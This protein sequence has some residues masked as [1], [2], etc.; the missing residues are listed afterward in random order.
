MKLK[1]FRKYYLNQNEKGFTDFINSVMKTNPDYV[2]PVAKKCCRLLKDIK[3][4]QETKEKIYYKQ[5]FI[6]N[7]VDLKGKKIAVIDDAVKNASTLSEH[8]SYFEKKGAQV[9][10]YA[11]VGKK[12]WYDCT[13]ENYDKNAIAFH[14]LNDAE[15]ETYIFQQAQ[16][17]SNQ[18]TLCFDNEHLAFR[19]NISNENYE[20]LCSEL[21]NLGYVEIIDSDNNQIEKITLD[22]DRFFSE[23]PYF[24]NENIQMGFINKLRL[25]YSFEENTLLIFPLSFPKWSNAKTTILD[26]SNIPFSLPFDACESNIEKSYFNICFLYS[27]SLFKAF[28]QK[29]NTFFDSSPVLLDVDLK[30]YLKQEKVNNIIHS[31]S[32]FIINNNQQYTFQKNFYLPHN[33]KSF[34]SIDPKKIYTELKSKYDKRIKNNKAIL[35]THF[36]MPISKMALKYGY[37]YNLSSALDY[38]CD[39]GSIVSKNNYNRRTDICERVFRSGEVNPSINLQKSKVI[40]PLAIRVLGKTDTKENTVFS[41]ATKTVKSIAN[42]VVDFPDNDHS[43][44]NKPYL[45]GPVPHVKDTLNPESNSSIYNKKEEFSKYY[46]FDDKKFKT[47]NHNVIIEDIKKNLTSNEIS[48]YRSYFKLLSKITKLFGKDRILTSLAI[49]RD[50]YHYKTYIIYNITNCLDALGRCVSKISSCDFGNNLSIANEHAESSRDKLSMAESFSQDFKK[51]IDNFSFDDEVYEML[52]HIISN[53]Y[54][55]EDNILNTANQFAPLI[56]SMSGLVELL[57]FLKYFDR[58][59]YKTCLRYLKKAQINCQPLLSIYNPSKKN[60]RVSDLTEEDINEMKKYAS[61]ILKQ[62]INFYYRIPNSS[63]TLEDV[64]NRNRRTV[65]SA[66]EIVTRK[67]WK[68]ITMIYTDLTGYS[69]KNEYEIDDCLN[70]YYTKVGKIC[71]SKNGAIIS[72]RG[73]K[74]DSLTF[75]FEDMISAVTAAE[76]LLRYNTNIKIGISCAEIDVNNIS[77]SVNRCWKDVKMCAELKTQTFTNQNNLI[78]S[79]NSNF[80]DQLILESIEGLD[81]PKYYLCSINP[82]RTLLNDKSYKENVYE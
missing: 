80:G 22:A 74:D 43:F 13:I 63:K 73:T 48:Q 18:K 3:I 26:F 17:I 32:H 14:L 55:E 19:L 61:D 39:L 69:N 7:N 23:I 75:I 72:P 40:V 78:C 42:F 16:Y 65:N 4:N 24:L 68:Q 44:Y 21:N 6:F 76:E 35:G 57:F 81:N 47:L 34:K 10:T 31:V 15:Y 50:E 58:N 37:S 29:T 11:F 1:T 49:C 62:A 56:F 67:S 25:T 28:F 79:C 20:L 59:K 60:K 66:V 36:Y 12:K 8:R 33:Q 38:L 82:T 71:R 53:N 41:N 2:V 46:T 9:Q 51:I 52:D 54:F 70:K 77:K 5:Y 30:H 27:I 64:T 45:F